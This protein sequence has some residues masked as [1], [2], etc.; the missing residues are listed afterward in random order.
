MTL[1]HTP[2]ELQNII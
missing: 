2:V 1:E